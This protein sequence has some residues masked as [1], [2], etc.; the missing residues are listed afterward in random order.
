MT[1]ALQVSTW[2]TPCGIGNYTA[3]LRQ[4]LA[5]VGIDSE[6]ATINRHE[7]SMLSKP[8]VADAIRSLVDRAGDH[9][10]VHI[11]HEFSF[12]GGSYGT[13]ASIRNFAD[14]VKHA[15]TKAPVVTTFHTHPFV[16]R[17]R[18]PSLPHIALNNALAL[19]WRRQVVPLF[20]GGKATAVVPSRGLR[21]T[22]ADSGLHLD[23]VE[24]I[25][26]GAPP[27]RPTGAGRDAARATLGYRDEDRVLMLFGFITR[28]K[29]HLTAL[30]A[31][32]NLPSNYKLAIVGGPHPFAGDDLFY[33]EVLD[34]L[35]SRSGLAKRVRVTGFV[36]D[37]E[38]QAYFDAADMC[39]LPYAEALA[40]SAA[41]MWAL[42]S[43][44]PVIGTRI[45]A[46]R[47][48]DQEE[49]CMQLV[50]VAAPL[51]LAAAVL[52]VAREPERAKLMV[53]NAAAFCERHAWPRIAQQHVALYQRLLAQRRP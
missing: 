37:A 46:F 41:A 21:R 36:P 26:Q 14:L 11:Q 38:V 16:R 45:P 31:L 12:F 4:G 50:D 23:R 52:E 51:Q 53:A 25:A 27:M 5:D 39:V 44:R 6:I 40:T 47:E 2:D 48:I 8:E 30:D 18:G 15:R 7:L 13:A 20:N 24:H 3:G 43:G 34:A 19:Q 1:S 42:A 32:T 22:L 29:G 28:Y 49:D 10:I 33:E 35:V 9:D 17:W